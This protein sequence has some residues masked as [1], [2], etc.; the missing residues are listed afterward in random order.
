M[1]TQL[2][3]TISTEAQATENE[4][5][6]KIMDIVRDKVSK[7]ECDEIIEAFVIA[8]FQKEQAGW[9]RGFRAGWEA[10]N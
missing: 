6:S 5:F 10:N 2:V 4:M 1:T 3:D 8:V 9:H 7:K